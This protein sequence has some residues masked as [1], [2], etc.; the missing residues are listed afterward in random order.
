[1]VNPYR[2]VL[3]AA[4]VWCPLAVAATQPT[5]SPV[6][7]VIVVDTDQAPE[8]KDFGERVRVVAQRW[9]PII[10]ADLPG[11]GFRP[12]ARVT[13][14][15]KHMDGIAYT[16]GPTITCAA[17]WFTDHPDD[18]GAVVHE[19][20]HV[21]QGYT[22]GHRPGWLVEGIADYIRWFKYEPASA[23]P[24]PNPAHAKYS[25]SYRTTAAFLD[26]AVPKYDAD[27]VRKL[28]D[29]CRG[30]HYRDELW[31]QYTGKT[32]DELG[33]EWIE[34]LRAAQRKPSSNPHPLSYSG[35]H[36]ASRSSTS[37]VAIASHVS[38]AP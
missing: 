5:T 31:K 36:S 34:S 14:V 27:L 35:S 3:V 8:M 9:Y 30:G 22:I 21:V 28:N 26:W 6:S 12:P 15:F 10:A 37:A 4:L 19:L 25:D 33:Q 18:V 13:I 29:A 7:T 38:A 24:H 11:D 23:R 32:A 2:F 17:K 16:T 1:M 20:V